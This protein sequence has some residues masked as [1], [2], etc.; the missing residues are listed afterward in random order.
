MKIPKKRIQAPVRAAD[1]GLSQAVSESRSIWQDPFI[2]FL[3]FLALGFVVYCNTINVPF[4]FDDATYL[5]QNPAIK[6]F[7]CFPN[8]QKVVEYAIHQDIK[9]NFILRPVA[10]FTFAVNYALHGLDLFGYHLVNLLLHIGC[11]MLVYSF[12][13]QL[14]NSPAMGNGEKSGSATVAGNTSN[15]PL[16]AALLFVSHPLQTQAVTYIIQR[17][18][19]LATF[20]YLAALVLYLEFRR[21][22]TPSSRVLTYIFSFIATLL[23][24]ESKEIAF[25]LPLIIALVEFM[26]NSGNAVSRVVTL[27]PFLLTMAIIPAKLMQ[28]PASFAVYKS[29]DISG[30]I[31][32]VNAGGTS[33]LDYLMTQFG[34]ITTYLRLLILPIHQ[35]LDYDYR[36]QQNFFTPEVLLPLALL[37]GIAGIGIYLMRR[38]AENRLYTVAAFGIFWFFIT[39][40]VESS[41]VPIEDLIFEHRAYLPSIGFFIT[42]LSGSAIFFNRFTGTSMAQSKWATTL[43]L[44]IIAGLTTT[45]IARNIV[46]LDDI[47]FWKDV[48]QKSPDKARTHRGLAGV[49]LQHAKYVPGKND[50]NIMGEM[51]VLRADGEK[52]L[53]AAINSSQEAIRLDPKK[54]VAHQLLAE[55]F[56]LRKNYDE[57]L[58]SLAKAAELEPKSWIPHSMRGALFQAKN[59]RLQ[60]H[61]EYRT[62]IEVEPLAYEPHIRLAELYAQEG[63]IQAAITELEFVM[64][65]YP[66]E[67]VRKK[68]AR[69]KSR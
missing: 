55:A 37:L 36:L 57:A 50:K 35:N 52:L 53:D 27:S 66:D 45:A 8:T 40:S 9:N 62:A 5:I 19:P 29:A 41:I 47:T 56:M 49:L 42:M 21:A 20:F 10:Y 32:L 7:D 26:F 69:L 11:S 43:L 24:M 13:G 25:T 39:L 68:L 22:A 16:F 38:S 60:A 2:H 44:V 23:A 65:I 59:D 61:R 3:L 6:N 30:A 33:S 34:V 14:L 15:L 31:N 28:L 51:V 12:F 48:V 58:R 1:T 54:A 4:I 17:F 67:S 63:N 64:R 18:V 46:W